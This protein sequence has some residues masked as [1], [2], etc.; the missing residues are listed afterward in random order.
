MFARNHRARL[1]IYNER[2]IEISRGPNFKLHGICI[3]LATL[4][5]QTDKVL[6]AQ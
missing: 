3:K 1:N 5:C 6:F 4:G 2:Q